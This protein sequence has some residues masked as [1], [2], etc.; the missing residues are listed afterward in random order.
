MGGTCSTHA[1]DE[2]CLRGGVAQFDASLTALLCTCQLISSFDGSPGGETKRS[3]KGGNG[4][5]TFI[6]ARAVAYVS[7]FEFAM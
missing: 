7:Q 1:R 2:K 4:E 6:I 5:G 3:F